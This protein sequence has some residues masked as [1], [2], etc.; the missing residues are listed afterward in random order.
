LIL[1]EKSSRW[2]L[3]LFKHDPAMRGSELNGFTRKDCERLRRL[4]CSRLR[5]KGFGAASSFPL[6]R[7]TQAGCSF[8]SFF[9]FLTPGNLITP[10]T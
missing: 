10:N 8:Q 2:L 3:F 4:Q 7:F 9:A 5:L 6:C 1:R